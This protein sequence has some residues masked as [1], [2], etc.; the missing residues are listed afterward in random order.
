M[1]KPKLFKEAIPVVGGSP[2]VGCRSTLELVCQHIRREGLA[3]PAEKEYA[4]HK[5]LH[6]II[7]PY[8]ALL[9]E[10]LDESSILSELEIL[11][12]GPEVVLHVS[13]DVIRQSNLSGSRR[14][15]RLSLGRVM[16]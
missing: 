13:H 11:G 9:K 3:L 8:F 1:V 12:T 7:G 14:C 5:I 2:Y 4:E 15:S 16:R 6:A 10:P